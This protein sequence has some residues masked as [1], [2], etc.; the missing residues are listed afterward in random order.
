MAWKKFENF[1]ADM[2]KRPKGMTLDRI[3][4]NGD[5]SPENCRWADRKTQARNKRN[6]H[7]IEHAGETLTLAE[8][9][10]RAN[11]PQWKLKQRLT[12]DGLTFAE[13]IINGDRR[14][15]EVR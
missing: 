8:W 11:M 10:E 4:V 1:Y 15:G 14:S 3:D 13:A 9:A 2:G 12:R 7:L 5:Y 6:N